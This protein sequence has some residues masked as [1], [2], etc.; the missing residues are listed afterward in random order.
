MTPHM[1]IYEKNNITNN[2]ACSDLLKRPLPVA[3]CE[4]R[5][6]ITMP[7]DNKK[8]PVNDKKTP[9]DITMPVAS[10]K[11]QHDF[12]RCGHKITR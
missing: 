9:V 8:T 6:D 1:W 5:V 11:C 10:K 12:T 2:I 4:L 7:V 3:R